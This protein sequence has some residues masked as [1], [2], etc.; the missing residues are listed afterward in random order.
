MFGFRFCVQSE[1][2]TTISLF[3]SSVGVLPLM[4][5]V[6]TWRRDA[7]M[8]YTSSKGLSLLCCR[9][10]RSFCSCRNSLNHA[11]AYYISRSRAAAIFAKASNCSAPDLKLT[12]LDGVQRKRMRDDDVEQCRL[13][14]MGMPWHCLASSTPPRVCFD[15]SRIFCIFRI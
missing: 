13:P 7:C 15:R 9:A 10:L 1:V 5:L 6:R 2:P 11:Q 4:Y 3:E 12:I 8:Q 14:P